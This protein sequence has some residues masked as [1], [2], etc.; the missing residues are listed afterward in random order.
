MWNEVQ[1]NM[2]VQHTFGAQ[3]FPIV[4]N[5]GGLED[6]QRSKNFNVVDKELRLIIVLYCTEKNK[7]A[8]IL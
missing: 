2:M 1:D 3:N 7:I 6:P 5:S 4:D 8:Y